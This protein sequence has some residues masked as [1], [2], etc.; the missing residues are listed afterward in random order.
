MTDEPSRG[1]LSSDGAFRSI[2]RYVY[3][4]SQLV[5]HMRSMM[6]RHLN[7]TP[8]AVAELAFA[9][10]PPEQ[11]ATA[12]FGMC[13]TVT[14]LDL[15]E[16]KTG[17]RLHGRV[18]EAIEMRS[19]VAH[20]DW[21]VG[22]SVLGAD[23]IE[24]SAR[25]LDARSGALIVLTNL[26]AEYGA[27]CLR[28]APYAVGEHRVSDYLVMRAGE[29]VREG[30]K[31]VKSPRV[32][33]ETAALTQVSD[34]SAV[35]VAIPDALGLEHSPPEPG[36]APE[37][38]PLSAAEP[39]PPAAV[40]PERDSAPVVAPPPV[41]ADAPVAA[42]RAPLADDR[43]L[44]PSHRL[45]FAHGLAAIARLRNAREQ[46][47][48][49]TTATAVSDDALPDWLT[50]HR[51]RHAVLALAALTAAL[52]SVVSYGGHVFGSIEQNTIDTR[53]S[54]R[55]TQPPPS[56]IVIVAIDNDSL[57]TLG[58]F[59]FRRRFDA[60]VI[61][62]V[63]AGGAKAIGV[64]L[65]FTNQTDATDD[66]DL[67][68]AVGGAKGIV[69]STTFV[70]ANGGTDV[71]GDD[72][73][74]LKSQY[75]AIA[76][77]A[78]VPIDNAA[79]LRT[80]AYSRDDLDT[81]GV[82]LAQ[83]ATGHVVSRAGFPG[84]AALVDFAGPPNTFKMVPFWEVA[85]G[86]VPAS[87]FRGK[88]VL[89]GATATVL[90]DDHATPVGPTMSGVEYWANAVATVLRGEPLRAASGT[91]N[92]LLIVLF[93]LCMPALALAMRPGLLMVGLAI[94]LGVA[95]AI[96]TQLAFNG[97]TVLSFVYPILALSL[98][99]VEAT[100]GDLW[101]ER[102]H[103]RQL[104]VY[105]AAYEALPSAASAGFFISYRR[106][107]SSWPARILRDELVRR[108]GEAQVF[109]DA[110]SIDAGQQWPDRLEKAISGASVVLVLIGPSW[111]D[112][113]SRDGERRLENPGDWVRLEVEAA[114]SHEQIAVV[115]VLLDG[116][117]MPSTE[118]L[119]DS[120]KPLGNR[121]ALS[122][123]AERWSDDVED[124][125]DSIQSGRIRDYLAKQSSA[126]S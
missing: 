32:F 59:P 54:I 103:R 39:V 16:E 115:P 68:E 122:L 111:A 87:F 11:I 42:E 46:R 31:A 45:R 62:R 109:M 33:Y 101:A 88:I 120:L 107:Q 90:Q 40:V 112:A 92:E 58:Q 29:V 18:R 86:K 30:P 56:D 34:S 102:R 25:D 77:N 113:R 4:F 119:P 15:E 114:L 66:N 125:I 71:F 21:W 48:P 99:T 82:A 13:R 36:P 78:Y 89:I 6:T 22:S 47:E 96:V 95:Y 75:G 27:V 106:D 9:E 64:D 117:T 98:G 14:R 5:L 84:G 69:L 7:T 26:V 52:L 28:E 38:P 35:S 91:L 41:V 63:H 116:A 60:A 76:A 23:A 73:A 10:S 61:N 81:F 79:V 100:A 70:S 80:I 57:D 1:G 121:H 104:E 108:F 110:D 97:G 43:R 20:G 74:Q 53:F 19:N 65:Q 3:E 49:G 51:L 37:P 44:R 123:S 105:K 85:R 17:A 55:G 67:I 8:Q 50:H 118:T 124:L 83:Q 94:G 2:G 72:T 12:F 126:P 24:L 93:A